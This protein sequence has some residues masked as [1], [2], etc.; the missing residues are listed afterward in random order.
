MRSAIT[1]ALLATAACDQVFGTDLL[2][3]DA[4]VDDAALE[5]DGAIDPCAAD[6]P[7]VADEDG[8]RIKDLCDNCPPLSNPDQA[9]SDNDGVGDPCD[10]HPQRADQIGRFYAFNDASERGDFREDGGS[11]HVTAG[12]YIQERA[13]TA[14]AL[15][16]VRFTNAT[17]IAVIGN[18][19]A[20]APQASSAVALYVSLAPDLSSGLYCDHYRKSGPDDF[21]KLGRFAPNEVP[22]MTVGPQALPHVITLSPQGATG[23]PVCTVGTQQMAIAGVG[24]LA[25]HVALGTD[26]SIIDVKS[27][28]I[29][30]P[31]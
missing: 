19:S 21:S 20:P 3:P 5:D 12:S 4:A 25:G 16:T 27:L 11:W 2:R 31:R 23:T 22:M 6:V 28:T 9:D 17:A 7:P 15:L 8:D 18:T 1:I 13:V 30:V 10:I 26:N 14:S 29:I 24:P